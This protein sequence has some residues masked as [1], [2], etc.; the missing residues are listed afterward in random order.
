MVGAIAKPL[1]GKQPPTSYPRSSPPATG[2]RARHWRQSRGSPTPGN[3]RERGRNRPYIALRGPPLCVT[4]GPLPERVIGSTRWHELQSLVAI[5]RP[6]AGSPPRGSARP[7]SGKANKVAATTHGD[8]NR[9]TITAMEQVPEALRPDRPSS[10][11]FHHQ[12]PPEAGYR[13][14]RPPFLCQL[15][16]RKR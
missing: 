4:A 3:P 2:P 15:R 16:F 13:L 14:K 10:D 6:D 11:L 5:E 1:L 9:C 12:R 8:I 7:G